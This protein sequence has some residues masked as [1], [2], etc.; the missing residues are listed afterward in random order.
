MWELQN[1]LV[2]LIVLAALAYLV[3]KFFLKKKR[4]SHSGCDTNCGCH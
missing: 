2:Y 4:N 1:I 3:K